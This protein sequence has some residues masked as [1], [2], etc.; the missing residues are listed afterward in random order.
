VIAII[1]VVCCAGPLLL[2]ALAATGA[3]AW[4]ATH[5]YTLGA[6]ALI[7]LAALL[8]WRINAR[9]SRG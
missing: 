2:G 5:G 1:A 6:A 9:I 3:G 4:L 8:A 7:V